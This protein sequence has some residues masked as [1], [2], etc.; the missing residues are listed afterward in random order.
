MTEAYGKLPT[1]L[2]DAD[3]R[4]WT[5]VLLKPD[6]V[7]R[8]LVDPVLTWVGSVVTIVDRRLVAPTEDQIT[9]HYF[10]LLT[11]RRAHFTWVDVAADLRRNYVGKRVGIALGYGDNA[12]ARLR[13][14]LGHYDPAQAGPDTIRGRFGLDSLLQAMAEGRLIDNLIHSSDHA[15]GAAYEF[16][17]WYGLDCTDLLQ[18]PTT[19]RKDTP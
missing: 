7:A 17:I 4:R 13:E 5:V 6:C 10:D 12:A 15:A 11:T 16:A 19:P 3:W 9:A 2:A 18:P 1:A 14:L 8:G